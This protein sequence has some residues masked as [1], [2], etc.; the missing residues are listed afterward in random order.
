M[1]IVRLSLAALCVSAFAAGILAQ[2]PP[3]Q[4]PQLTWVRYFDVQPGRG[5]DFMARMR[6]INVPLFD[7]LMKENA[8]ASWGVA[9]PFLMGTGY[10]HIIWITGADW[11]AFDRV[12][13][14]IDAAEKGRSAEENARLM[15]QA[16]EIYRSSPRDIILRHQIQGAPA[17]ANFRPAYIRV[18]YFAVNPGRGMDS[19]AHFRDS[20]VPLYTDMQSRGVI[21]AWGYSSQDVAR[22]DTWTHMGWYFVDDLASFD[23][24]RDAAMARP[25]ESRD[26][27]AARTR[28]LSDSSKFRTEILRI[29]HLGGQPAR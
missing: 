27:W 1:R 5:A 23:K 16:G 29:T 15:A 8:I 21:E 14:A 6:Q 19:V 17:A 2:T 4:P 28:E 10:T 7:R 22:D 24:V 13:A 18:N 20:T 12:V 11:S 9:V 26:R 25:Q 3:A